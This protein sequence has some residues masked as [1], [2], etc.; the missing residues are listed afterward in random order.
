MKWCQV[1]TEKLEKHSNL[2]MKTQMQSFTGSSILLA[3]VMPAQLGAALR[4]SYRD[5]PQAPICLRQW[6]AQQVTATRMSDSCSRCQ[7]PLGSARACGAGLPLP[8]QVRTKEK[9]PPLDGHRSQQRRSAGRLQPR[10]APS[11]GCLC[12]MQR[13]NM[14]LPTEACMCQGLRSPSGESLPG[15]RRVP[16]SRWVQE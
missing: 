8:S 4:T 14:V 12:A 15:R 16:G 3:L 5:E 10:L 13:L 1:L 7:C 2:N 11:A 6:P 9:G